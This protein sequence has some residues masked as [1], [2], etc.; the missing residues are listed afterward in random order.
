M[1]TK[2]YIT[3]TLPIFLKKNL[4][5]CF[6]FLKMEAG[7]SQCGEDSGGQPV[8]H[9]DQPEEQWVLDH[10]RMNQVI[11]SKNKIL[12]KNID[13]S[14]KTKVIHLQKPDRKIKNG[15]PRKKLSIFP[16]L[17]SYNS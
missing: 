2:N 10:G 12:D 13:N 9:C 16:L 8:E 17:L 3:G 11:N 15:W 7:S 5:I 6:F 4:P 1:W 14:Q